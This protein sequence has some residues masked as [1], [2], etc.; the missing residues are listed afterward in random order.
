[1]DQ[2]VSS[3]ESQEKEPA[4]HCR[5]QRPAPPL[6]RHLIDRGRQASMIKQRLLYFFGAYTM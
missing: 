3:S 1:V 4:L 2:I 6:I 5:S